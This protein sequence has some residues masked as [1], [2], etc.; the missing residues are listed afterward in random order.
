MNH[1][2]SRRQ[3]GKALDMPALVGRLLLF[4]LFALAVSK[5]VSFCD[6]GKFKQRILEASVEISIGNHNLSGLHLAAVLIRQ[7]GLQAILSQIICQTAGPGSGS[8]Q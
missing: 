8:R 1:I 7:V 4:P 5:H 2:I 3:L 6:N